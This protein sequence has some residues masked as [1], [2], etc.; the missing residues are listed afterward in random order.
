MAQPHP[1]KEEGLA[2]HLVAVAIGLRALYQRRLVLPATRQRPELPARLPDGLVGRPDS[3]LQGAND[4]PSQKGLG[5]GAGSHDS[6]TTHHHRHGSA[7]GHRRAGLLVANHRKA[8]APKGSAA[9]P[10]EVI[11]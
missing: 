7:P 8:T 2:D 3:P 9:A 11:A 5:Q 1:T 4:E 10:A 6:S